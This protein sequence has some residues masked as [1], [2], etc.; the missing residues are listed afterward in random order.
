[1]SELLCLLGDAVAGRLTR[2]RRG[3]LAF[4]YD[5][6]WLEADD[7]YP[8]SLSLPLRAEPHE[9]E[10]VSAF[11]MNLLPDNEL[12]LERWARRF[13]V[14]ASNAFALL[15]A[16]GEDCAGAARFIASDRLEQL[17][18][19]GRNETEWLWEAQIAERLRTLREDVSAWRVE[20]DTGR[21]T[22]AGAQSKTALY[23]DGKRWGV[24]SGRTPTT[25]ILKPGV[26]GLAGHAENE[27]FCLALAETLGMACA[28]T[29][30]R[31][32]EDQIAICVERFDRVPVAGDMVRAHQ[33]DFCQAL[34]VHPAQKYESEGGPG[35]RALATVLREHSTSA[36]QDIDRL[37]D[38]LAFNWLIGG[39]D[40][41][42]KNFSLRIGERG[43]V[44]LAPL[45]DVASALPFE[46]MQLQKMKLAMKIG[47]KYRLRDVGAYEWGKLAG[48]L[49]LSDEHVLGRVRRL[50]NE[51]PDHATSLSRRCRG[52]G[53]N[54]TIIARIEGAIVERARFCLR[55][56]GG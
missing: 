40:G 7:A 22:L 31:T 41:H 24:P 35:V 54:A 27:H 38:A 30:V 12:I 14:P 13:Q 11:V 17:A 25:Q 43:H 21:F 23:F 28:S 46:G 49:G 33:E 10:R 16:V 15:G 39:T 9:H 32:F 20:G 8:L 48:E 51:I 19:E 2:D 5:A 36:A 3:Q 1:M 53:L 44:C 26:P 45:Y 4:V 55:A 34:G 18:R 42:A 47:G 50:A 37:V 6:A 29:E 52:E 56:V